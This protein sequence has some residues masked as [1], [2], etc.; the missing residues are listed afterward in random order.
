[1][2]RIYKVIQ[3]RKNKVMGS[4]VGQ[5][6]QGR[7]EN[8]DLMRYGGHLGNVKLVEQRHPTST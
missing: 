7:R 6:Y 8:L 4:L 2:K 3:K 5:R 1:M